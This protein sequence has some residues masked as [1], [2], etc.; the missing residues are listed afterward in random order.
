MTCSSCGAPQMNDSKP[1]IYVSVRTCPLCR[2][3][4]DPMAS[5]CPH[6][7]GQIGRLQDCIKCPKCSEMVVPVNIVATDEKGW[8]TDAAKAALGGGYY[9]AATTEESYTACPACRT[10]IAY[11]ATCGTVTPSILERKWVGVGRSKSGY[12]FKINCTSCDSK[13]AGPSC[14]LATAVCETSL[15]ATMLSLYRLR[16]L[17]LKRFAL[18]RLMISAYYRCSPR[19]ALQVAQRARVR[20]VLRVC[21]RGAIRLLSSAQ[22]QYLDPSI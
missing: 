12:Q 10:P 9:L 14:F 7:A 11:C 1:N 17:H 15:D 4:V 2:Q 13:V 18:G 3:P 5:R 22:E 16:D 20:T 6:C 8:Q 21:V 19:L